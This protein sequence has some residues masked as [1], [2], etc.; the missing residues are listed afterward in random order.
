MA[1]LGSI[2][3]NEIEL[4]EVDASPKVSGIDASTGSIASNTDGSFLYLKNGENIT[5]WA[6][7]GSEFFYSI[8][9]ANQT[10]NNANYSDV[11]EL[12]TENLPIGVY[13]FECFAICQST[14]TS[15]GIGLRL[16]SSTA[17]VGATFG[18]WMI[19]QAANGTASNFQ[20]DQTDSITNVSS[21]SAVAANS[22]FIVTGEGIVNVTTAGSI[23]VQ[24]RAENNNNV[25]IRTGS[26]LFLKRVA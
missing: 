6:S 2:T 13:K 5:D 18:K 3:V 10:K 12:T 24:I 19:R 9:T 16:G 21:T 17:T 26:V 20:Y 25:S 7:V 14:S 11:T 8:S 4:M 22:D 15:V 1:V 23:A